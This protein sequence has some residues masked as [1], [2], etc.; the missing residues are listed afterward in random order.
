LTLLEFQDLDQANLPLASSVYDWT[1][2]HMWDEAGFFYY[3]KLPFLTIKTPYMRWSQ[4]WML[5]ALSTFAEHEI[6][7]RAVALSRGGPS[8][9]VSL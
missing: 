9:T 7:R 5:L 6:K 4:A 8:A 1:I 2:R 3:R